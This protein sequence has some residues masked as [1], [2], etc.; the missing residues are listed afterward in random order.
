ME[1]CLILHEY[2]APSSTME[3]NDVDDRDT[4]R[5]FGSTGNGGERVIQPRRA[6]S[7]ARDG[8]RCEQ[9]GGA[10]RVSGSEIVTPP[11]SVPAPRTALCRIT[12]RAGHV[13]E[14][15]EWPEATW[16]AALLDGVSGATP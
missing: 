13:I 8:G 11:E 4:W 10:D 9:R 2:V 7:Q 14:F 16:L 12:H 3:G 1:L 6:G 15:S 5:S